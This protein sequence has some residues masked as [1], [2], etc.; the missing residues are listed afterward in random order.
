MNNLFFGKINIR[1]VFIYITEQ[2]NLNCDYC[3]FHHK[4]FNRKLNLRIVSSF[5][6]LFLNH[7]KKNNIHF[8]ISGGEPFLSWRL[9]QN[10][11]HYIKEHFR[12][13]RIH[14][15]TNGTFLD[16]KKVLFLKKRG[17]GIE[18]GIDG[19]LDSTVKHRKNLTLNKYK[20]LCKNIEICV[21]LNIP[22]S[23]TMT[24]HPK[25]TEKMLKNFAYLV[26]L[27]I[28][29]IDITPA[30]FMGWNK[31]TIS[32]FKE[33][34]IQIVKR[35]PSIGKKFLYIAEDTSAYPFSWD[36]SIGYD[37]NIL[38]G[39]VY[40]CLPQE[41]KTKYSIVTFQEETAQ[42]NSNN[43]DFFRNEYKKNLC[44]SGNKKFLHRDF[45]ITSFL[46]LSR[47]VNQ[48]IYKDNSQVMSALLSFIKD[49]NR[50]LIGTAGPK[51]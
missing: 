41:L 36:F 33:N 49:S 2:C 11:V 50:I 15:Q 9:L 21:R 5:L 1:N 10:T 28:K 14:I 45:V 7:P 22:V 42:L 26:S 13:N 12:E 16:L 39:D 44:C 18:F 37:G 32:R 27:G 34:Y 4:K 46:I 24:V 31:Y 23:A 51:N 3:Y 47:M 19:D 8:I 25:E 29:N 43:Y 20:K 30:A 17:V 40:L 35:I 48:K 6:K 38:P